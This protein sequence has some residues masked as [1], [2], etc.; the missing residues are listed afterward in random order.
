M[1]KQLI[2][3]IFVLTLATIACSIDNIEMDT[4]ETQTVN[5]DESLPL[6]MEETTI[7]FNM[8]GGVFNLQS[9]AEGLVNGTITY[10]V[11][12]W[13]PEYTRRDNAYEIRQVNPFSITG[14]PTKNIENTWDLS[15]S[16]AVLIDLSIEGGASE[17]NFDFT[18]LQLTNLRIL[19]GASASIIL[20]NTPNPQVMEEFSF[21]TG[22]S[23]AELYSLANA[24]FEIMNMSAGAGDYT[25]DFTGS[26]L[27][28]DAR[29]D[30]KAGISNITINIPV[31]MKVQVT[32][33][34]TVSNI[35]TKGTW[36]LTDNTYSTLDEGYT[37][38]IILDMAVGNVN[39]NRAE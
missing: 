1:K 34:G 19:Q 29:I 37:L 38:T 27:S 16:T 4:I 6:N 14:I 18:G 5:I 21:T 32:N 23:S 13:E 30:I 36:L 26:S 35:N 17:Y 12:Q 22:A 11:E 20:F 28:H 39:L 15:L 25:L 24:N 9:G 31:G 3:V 7:K 33:N 2:A 10:N 8:T